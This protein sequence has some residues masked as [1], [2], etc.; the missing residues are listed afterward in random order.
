MGYG[1]RVSP[2][3]SIV[4]DFYRYIGNQ[5]L[6]TDF[7]LSLD[8]TFIVVKLNGVSYR[9]PIFTIN[10]S[11]SEVEINELIRISKIIVENNEINW[12]ADFENLSLLKLWYLITH[13]KYLQEDVKFDKYGRIGFENV[14]EPFKEILLA[15]IADILS[16]ALRKFFG[17]YTAKKPVLYLTSDYDH[18]NIWDSWNILDF[19]KEIYR[20]IRNLSFKKLAYTIF[21]YFFSR[22]SLLFNGYLNDKAFLFK[23]NV[24][25]I[26]FFIPNSLNELYDG[27]INYSDKPVIRFL[28]KLKE[29][30]VEFGLHTS[31]ETM[32]SPESIL[33][34][35]KIMNEK[36]GVKPQSNRHHYLR[37]IFPK[38]LESLQEINIKFD[39]SMY[40]PE[41]LVFRAGISSPYMVWNDKEGRPYGLQIIPTTLMDGT[42]T[43]YL[44][45]NYD[46]ALNLCLEKLSL[47]RRYG[48]TIVLLWHNSSL[49]RYYRFNNYH[50]KLYRRILEYLKLK[51]VY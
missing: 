6:N 11:F 36:L 8:D 34:Q 38:Y 29:N 4:L 47:S 17:V 32:D 19:F 3:S 43:D 21:S 7:E 45:V 24:K 10:S 20:C 35:N 30:K 22:H 31:F 1:Q 48:S 41:S 28:N 40:Y 33:V 49:F 2:I 9:E 12:K 16:I 25:N 14:K 44:D 37:F 39:F 46:Q 5:I 50:P 42:F 13:E 23:E 15:P 26:A 51:E 27:K 18:M